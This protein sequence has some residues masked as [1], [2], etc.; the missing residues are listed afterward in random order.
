MSGS[1]GKT[2]EGI[3]SLSITVPFNVSGVVSL[4]D[5]GRVMELFLTL[6][7]PIGVVRAIRGAKRGAFVAG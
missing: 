7:V 4:G 2:I 5:T 1:F 3:S 6:P